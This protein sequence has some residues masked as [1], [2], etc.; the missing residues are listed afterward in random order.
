EC[1]VLSSDFKLPDAS[2]VLLRVPRE[3]NIY[4]VNLRNIVPSGDLTCLFAK[5]TLDES[6]LWHRRLGH[7]NFKN[8]NKLVK[9]NLVRGLPTKFCRLKGIKR[10]FSVPRTSQQN[11]I[12][13]RKNRTLVEA[14][15]TILVDSLLPIPFWAEAVNTTCYVQ[16][17][18]LV[19]KP[20]NKTP[21]ELLHGRLPSIGFMRPFGCPITI[22][23]TLDHLGKF[24]GKVDEGF[25]VGYSMCSKAFRVCNIRTRIVQ[26]T[27]HVNFMENKP[28][29][30][31]SGPTWLFDIDSLTRTMNY[32]PVVAENQTNSHADSLIDE[33]ENDDDIQKSVSPNIHSSSSGVQTRKQGK[34]TE[35]KD[36]A[37]NSSSQDA[38]TSTHD[39]DMPNLEDL[40]HSDDAVDDERGIVIRNK[41]RL[42]AQGHT[43]EE[44]IDYEEV[45]APVARIEAIRLFLAYASFMGFLVYQ[46]DL[47]S[48][49]LYGT[50]EEEV[51]VWKQY[52]KTKKKAKGKSPVESFI[53][54]RDLSAEFKDHYENSSNDVNVAGS[55]V[56]TVGQ[57]SSN[58]TNPFR[59]SGPLNTTASPTHG[60]SSVI[61]TK[62]V[63]KNKKDERGIV[64]RNKARLVI[65]GHTHEE[66]IDYE[67]VF[68]R[69]AR[70]EAIRLFLAY[71]SFMG[72]MEY[73]MDVKSAFL[74][75]TI[76]EE[77]YVCQPPGFKDHDHPDK[78]YKVVK[79][80]Y[81]LHQDP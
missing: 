24:Q 52:D 67:E 70:I 60:K 46:M 33:K 15:R 22:L 47:K 49:F 48:A 50:I 74:Y 42:V 21:Y 19:T 2:Q 45:F 41:A 39:L 12:A 8:I 29:V 31:C 14:A 26:E 34:K 78:I 58:I 36:K 28:N 68:A 7:V 76:K 13:E 30:T 55:I 32:H 77:V 51:Y 9:G 65:Q 80:L 81:G 40:S 62:W 64:V 27:L 56:P 3:N 35:N 17:R 66:G 44:G 61:G 23:N 72:F 10:E 16:N 25:L 79:A 37:A 11:G 5:A 73:Q 71:A 69:V 18:V 1:L 20:H 6:N 4:N 53:G 43:Q 54:N 38:S 57:N 63:Y 59:A 75:G